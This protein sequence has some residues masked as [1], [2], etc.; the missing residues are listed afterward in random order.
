MRRVLIVLVAGLF[1]TSGSVPAARAEPGPSAVGL[2]VS[3]S[4]FDTGPSGE[5]T[6]TRDGTTWR[7]TLAGSSVQTPIAG[8]SIRLAFP[9]GGAF[10]GTIDGTVLRG[11][12]VRR[13]VQEDP[14]FPFGAALAYAERLT[15][16]DAGPN[17]WHAQVAPLP[18]TLTLFISIF[19]D[20]DGSLKAAF[21][22]PELHE[23]GVAMQYAAAQNGDDLRFTARPD[24]AHP[25]SVERATLEHHPERLVMTP[26]GLKQVLTFTR[27]TADEALR[28]Y[29]RAPGSPPY[30]Y[31]V[32]AVTAD[33]WKVARAGDTGIDEAALARVVQRIAAIDPASARAWLIH[34]IAIAHHGRLVLDEYFYGYGRDDPHDMRSASKTFSSVILGAAMMEGAPLS[35]AT[36]AYDVMAPRGPF[37]NPDVRKQRI[38]L[39]HL[40][41]H[42][43]GLACDDNADASPGN[44]DAIEADRAH[45][46]WVKV[47]L[48]LPMQYEPGTHYAY[49]SMNT[50]LV[51]A[52]LTQS[53]GEWLPLLFDRTVARPLQFG[54]YFW[55]IMPNGEGYLGGGAFV[56]TR[57]FLKLGQ[58]YLDDGVWNG[59]RLVTSA[60]AKDSL[61]PH[62][63]ISP[64]TTG[65]EGDAF[66]NNYY[67]VDD[68]WAWHMI[69]VKSG[70]HVYPAYHANGNGGQLLLVV[71]Q[72][73]LVVMF[74][75]GNYGQGLWNRERDDIVGGMII[76][77]IRR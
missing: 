29:P 36:R 8:R 12:W 37:A 49:C 45:P 75:A 68:G 21:R 52:V 40:L 2:W 26:L 48:D 15:L 76:P 62:A 43:A 4:R 56:R 7:A 57:D 9:G 73:D 50:N 53:T 71:P 64:A 44:E 31:S 27:A 63:H 59:T 46:D 19:T 14:H 51:G 20:S 13:A 24:A 47:T 17:R 69:G 1:L 28:F 72:F 23:H 54:P 67:E 3:S 77:A 38:T 33:G 39:G 58:A 74:T 61:A 65:L 16:N 6:V 42:S 35:P 32:P 10:R 18:D 41:T 25:E 60:W 55:N 5:L 66:R 70:D 34:S 22:N 30:Q 11:F